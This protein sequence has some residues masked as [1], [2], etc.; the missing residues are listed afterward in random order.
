[1]DSKL[2]CR[3]ASDTGPEAEAAEADE[4]VGEADEDASAN[5]DVSAEAN[6][7]ESDADG[8]DGI[9][10]EKLA[11]VTAMVSAGAAVSEAEE[12]SAVEFLADP[13]LESDD[14]ADAREGGALAAARDDDAARGVD[15]AW[16]TAGAALALATGFDGDAATD[17]AAG[18]GVRTCGDHY[19]VCC[20]NDVIACVC[21]CVLKRGLGHPC[22]R[23]QMPVW[24]AYR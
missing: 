3:P 7:T 5:E 23:V 18:A 9:D 19:T 20:S 8:A 15:A 22:D 16:A 17:A 11:V 14:L 2:E 21:V 13:R 10:E 6:D 12:A 4:A 24:Q 1:M